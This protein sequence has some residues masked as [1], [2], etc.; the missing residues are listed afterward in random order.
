MPAYSC[1]SVE[2]FTA[3]LSIVG[4]FSLEP[5]FLNA[6][7]HALIMISIRPARRASFISVYFVLDRNP[8]FIMA[9]NAIAR[10]K[11]INT[12]IAYTTFIICRL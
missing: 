6:I 3:P 4:S 8:S 10:L 2:C 11:P 12:H 5:G 1:R 7:M 9:G